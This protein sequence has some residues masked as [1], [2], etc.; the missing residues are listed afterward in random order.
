MK[1]ISAIL[2]L[3]SAAACRDTVLLHPVGGEPCVI[4]DSGEV[5]TGPLVKEYTCH[6]G[7]IWQKQEPDGNYKEVCVNSWLPMPERCPLD[8]YTGDTDPASL[9]IDFDCDGI[10]NN[11]TYH[12]WD[13]LNP[14][15]ETQ[16]GV[17]AYS[18]YSCVDN[19]M[20]CVPPP[21]LYGPEIC[22][23][24]N[25]DEDCNGLANEDDP[26]IQLDG[27][28]Y[29]YD[30]D[31]STNL[32]GECRPWH[33]E[34][35]DGHEVHRGQV[36]PTPERCGTQRDEDCD[37]LVDEPE[38]QTAGQAFVILVDVSGSMDSVNNALRSA[39]C[40]WS[41]G[42][43]FHNSLFAIEAFGTSSF[44]D[45]SPY[46]N[47][48]ADFV[49]AQEACTKLTDYLAY[50]GGGGAEYGP[51]NVWAIDH[52][53]ITEFGL[54]WPN[55]MDRRVVLFS[56]EEPQAVGSSL[57]QEEQNVVDD[58][59]QFNFSLGVFT[60]YGLDYLWQSMTDGAC[61][62]WIEHL[63]VDADLMRQALEHRFGSEC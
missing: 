34:C 59:S 53:P 13:S 32:V 41:T 47:K 56:D 20:V 9:G 2:M 6:P 19:Q 28:E 10:P 33:N 1:I 5:I 12:Y 16:L 45:T 4:L 36:L 58:C 15:A 7:E 62:G 54:S 30:G 49:N 38:G 39:I 26:G 27:P 63:N 51:Y 46:I 50:N 11:L 52:T 35:L 3:M 44:S 61:Q 29:G 43:R 42:P 24:H 18:D 17:C 22:D 37:G 23:P 40:D 25:L 14:C 60:T 57:A 55:G 21:D 48:V 8:P 31:P